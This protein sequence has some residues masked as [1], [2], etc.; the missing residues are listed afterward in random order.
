MEQKKKNYENWLFKYNKGKNYEI[1][2]CNE[3]NKLPNIIAWRWPDVPEYVLLDCKLITIEDETRIAR[4]KIIQGIIEK[5]NIIMDDGIDIICKKHDKY[6]FIQCKDHT[7]SYISKNCLL[8]FFD[9]MDKYLDNIGYVYYTSGLCSTIKDHIINKSINKNI[10]LRKFQYHETK[11]KME[12]IILRDYQIEALNKLLDYFTINNRGILSMACGTG[13]TIVMLN[14]IKKYK[15]IIIFSPLKQ[16]A[17]QNKNRVLKHSKINYKSLIVDSDGDRDIEFITNYIN[18]YNDKNKLISATFKSVDIINKIIDL[19]DDVIIIIDEFH[20][21]SKNNIFKKDDEMYKLLNSN[22][23]ILFMSATPRI[24]EIEN[25]PYDTNEIFGE[26]VY[27]LSFNDAI[28]NKYIA[29]YRLCLPV[30]DENNMDLDNSIRN[31]VNIDNIDNLIKLKCEFLF[32]NILY[33]G[34]KKIILYLRCQTEVN[35]FIIALNTLN[36][37]YNV[38]YNIDKITSTDNYINRREKLKIFEEDTI[39]VQ[40]MLSIK[41]LDE[42]IDIPSCD[43]IFITYETPTK[44]RTIQRISRALRYKNNKCATI[45]L[46]CNL[47]DNLHTT[48]S[49][50]KEY[51]PDLKHKINIIN[52]KLNNKVIKNINDETNEEIIN[53][54]IKIDKIV[55]GIKEFKSLEWN[56]NL[57]KLKDFII[58]NNRIPNIGSDNKEE[59]YLRKWLIYNMNKY[60]NKKLLYMNVFGDFLK[61]NDII[62]SSKLW[63]YN[64]K[65]FIDNNNRI[66]KNNKNDTN[67][68]NLYKWLQFNLRKYE[69]DTLVYIDEFK[70]LITKYNIKTRKEQ[71]IN[72]LNILKKF[73]DTNKRVPYNNEDESLMYKWLYN[74][75]NNYEN[76]KL[77]YI[78]EFKIFIDD[79]KIKNTYDQW[80]EMFNK[81]Q[82]YVEINNVFPPEKKNHEGKKSII[83][84]YY[85]SSD[86]KDLELGRWYRN[87]LRLYKKKKIKDQNMINFFKKYNEQTYDTENKELFDIVQE[88]LNIHKDNSDNQKKIHAAYNTV[89]NKWGFQPHL[90]KNI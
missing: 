38:F 64:F 76:N 9:K 1:Y 18:M 35:E 28:K 58:N 23:K 40:I 73:I 63:S 2:I 22:Y 36:R 39:E 69:N 50:I 20:N 68:Y 47:Y 33:Y 41:I 60:E 6:I 7:T 70:L 48:L 34:L 55:I 32:K 46:W 12:K 79:Y 21:I 89:I 62:S 54:K 5:E 86:K 37:Y 24:Y 29:D 49:S 31:E 75:L 53:N 90:G 74:N 10:K 11:N 4:K 26:I 8:S 65:K 85:I 66:P 71:W 80:N 82:K 42:C 59:I 14:F 78:N 3:L 44:I 13:K 61:D 83:S 67:E 27:N 84:P 51:D 57:N 19:L 56:D 43:S 25:E 16:Y 81:L 17:I 87:Q 45:L 72:N 88:H 77:L 30:V 15:N 52:R